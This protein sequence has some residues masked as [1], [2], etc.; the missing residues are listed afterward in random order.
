MTM[1]RPSFIAGVLLAACLAAGAAHAQG[2]DGAKPLWSEL[3]PAQKSALQPLSGEWDKMDEARK[4][5]WLE[6]GN[7]FAAM[8][9]EEQQRMHERMREWLTLTPEQRRQ[10]R[11][12]Y[13]LSKKLDKSQKSASWD[14]YQQLPEEEKRKLAAAAAKKNQVTNLPPKSQA[15]ARPAPPKPAPAPAPASNA[16]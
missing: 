6:I 12:N 8:K 14:E 15:D 3:S 2:A 7:R 4:Q 10:A 5:K 1:A 11:E 13:F 16:K 9:P